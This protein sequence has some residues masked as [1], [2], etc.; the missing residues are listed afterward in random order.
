MSPE[1][2]GG[3]TCFVTTNSITFQLRLKSARK[4]KTTFFIDYQ[5]R[6][7]VYTW[8]Q[9]S[10]SCW[11]VLSSNYTLLNGFVY[12]LY[13]ATESSITYTFNTVFSIL[14]YHLHEKYITALQFAV[15]FHCN[16]RLIMQMMLPSKHWICLLN[17]VYCR[18]LQLENIFYLVASIFIRNISVL[19]SAMQNPNEDTEWNDILRKKGIIPEK[20]N[21]VISLSW[22]SLQHVES[23]PQQTSIGNPTTLKWSALLC[24]RT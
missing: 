1:L 21:T 10:L 11:Q 9:V 7:L 3:T 24:N 16:S 6:S 13:G 18:L 22:R 14:F 19:E 23:Q 15:A 5:L 4:Q 2:S 8:Y 12:L 20:V 17:N